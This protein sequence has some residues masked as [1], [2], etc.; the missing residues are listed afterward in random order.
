MT[1]LIKF[2]GRFELVNSAN[3]TPK[4][5]MTKSAGFLPEFEALK[6]RNGKLN[7]YLVA[8]REGMSADAPAMSLQAKNSLN[9]SGLKDY[10]VNGKLSGFAYGW[11]PQEAT[12]SAKNRPNPLHSCRHDGFLFVFKYEH[13]QEGEAIKP[14]SFELIVLD[15]MRVLIGQ[16]CKMLQVGGFNEELTQLRALSQ[17]V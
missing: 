10:Y 9:L 12:Y 17:D 4:Y 15:G 7:L 16:Y 11:P 6:G 13:Q 2:Y 8:K 5:T 3:K 1:P 14:S